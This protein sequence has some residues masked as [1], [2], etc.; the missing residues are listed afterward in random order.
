MT[1][2]GVERDPKTRV[3]LIL[4]AKN[5]ADKDLLSKSDPICV[6][7]HLVAQGTYGHHSG[8]TQWVEV[9]RTEQINNC[10]FMR[11]QFDLVLPR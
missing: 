6:V 8:G 5:I 7:Y 3:E 9:A 11:P 2:S 4:S 1:D 10:E